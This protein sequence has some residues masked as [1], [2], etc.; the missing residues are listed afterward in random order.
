MYSLF[1]NLQM[2]VEDKKKLWAMATFYGGSFELN[3]TQRCTHLVTG[4]PEGVSL[5]F[6]QMILL[7]F[8]FKLF[9]PS[10]IFT[11]SILYSLQY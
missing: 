5:L 8:S 9:F 11:S 1:F 3:L 7:F 2:S 4:K 6:Y 10:L